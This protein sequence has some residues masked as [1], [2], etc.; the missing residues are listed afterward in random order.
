[1]STTLPIHRL[2][3]AE[4]NKFKEHLKR[5]APADR[6]LRFGSQISDARIDRY[7]DGLEWPW[8]I[9]LVAMKDGLVRGAGECVIARHTWPPTAELAFSVEPAYQGQGIGSGLFERLLVV[10]RNRGISRIH[11]VTT[12]DNT[13]MQRMATRYGMTLVRNVDIEGRLELT[14]PTPTSLSGE[15]VDASLSWMVDMLQRWRASA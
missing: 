4:R 1:M 12:P 3:P 14:G 2:Y 6:R 8:A 13:R 5:L 7:V 10:A 11:I 9:T 15:W